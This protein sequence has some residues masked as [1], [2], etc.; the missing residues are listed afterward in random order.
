MEN[1]FTTSVSVKSVRELATRK[2]QA[3][4]ALGASVLVYVER[5]GKREL[6]YI[7]RNG[8]KISA[9]V[10]GKNFRHYRGYKYFLQVSES[11]PF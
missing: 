1:V 4:Q 5:K 7:T 3:A 2:F 9:T 6:M 11:L 10:N 8:K